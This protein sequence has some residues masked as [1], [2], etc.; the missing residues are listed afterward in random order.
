MA[1]RDFS[2]PVK[3]IYNLLPSKQRELMKPQLESMVVYVKKT[4]D[5]HGKGAEKKFRL[6]MLLYRHWLL[7]EKI[8]SED[9]F[10]KSFIQATTDRLWNESQ[11][12]IIKL[13]E[14]Q[15]NG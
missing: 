14:D 4:G 11:R 9:Y 12:L 13:R 5:T 2:K 8:V 15:I 3:E 1:E 6:F 10:G 7:S